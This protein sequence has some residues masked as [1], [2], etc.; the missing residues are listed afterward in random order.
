VDQTGR[1]LLP[2]V[3]TDTQYI[4][5]ALSLQHHKSWQNCNSVQSL[6]SDVNMFALD[7]QKELKMEYTAP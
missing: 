5:Y 3:E 2:W 6:K 7:L 4:E 1:L